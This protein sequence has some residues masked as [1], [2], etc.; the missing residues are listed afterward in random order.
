H[1]ASRSD[2]APATKGSAVAGCHVHDDQR[3]IAAEIDCVPDT[4]AIG[5]SHDFHGPYHDVAVGLYGGV[6]QRKADLPPTAVPHVSLRHNEPTGQ[7]GFTTI[8]LVATRDCLP[9]SF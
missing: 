4:S 5:R 7:A 8:R 1:F 9:Q 3:G 6:V 2:V